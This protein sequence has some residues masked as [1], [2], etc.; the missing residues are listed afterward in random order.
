MAERLTFR[1]TAENFLAFDW[2]EANRD[3][4]LAKHGI[5][6]ALAARIDW[7]N[8]KKAPDRRQVY[9]DNRFI[10]LAYC[11]AVEG[12][13]VVVYAK[14]NRIGRIISMRKANG[15]ETALFDA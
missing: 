12:V 6:F 15:Q 8:I 11:A 10:A 3:R 14:S 2:D 4:H 9:P 7:T 5:D 13:L 1:R